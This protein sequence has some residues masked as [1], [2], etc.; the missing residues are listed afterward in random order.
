MKSGVESAH[1][2]TTIDST[3]S[4]SATRALPPIEDGGAV[5]VDAGATAPGP[6]LGR[7]DDNRGPAPTH[8]LPPGS[9]ALDAADPAGCI[10]GPAIRYVADHR[11]ASSA[12]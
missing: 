8:F 3:V 4:D 5:A 7:L 9:L 12:L 6:G 11:G 10:D 2:L 1:A